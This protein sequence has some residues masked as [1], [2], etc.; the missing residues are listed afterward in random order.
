MRK[1]HPK[2]NHVDGPAATAATAQEHPRQISVKIPIGPHVAG[3]STY[4]YQNNQPN[5]GKYTVRSPMDPIGL[6]QLVKAMVGKHELTPSW[7]WDLDSIWLI[8]S[9]PERTWDSWGISSPLFVAWK[10]KNLLSA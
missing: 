3:I 8:P 2:K 1:H 4:I 6:I 5:V 9:H 10:S 7:L